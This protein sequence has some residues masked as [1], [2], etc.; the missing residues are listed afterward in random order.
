MDALIRSISSRISRSA[1]AEH[2]VADDLAEGRLAEPLDDAPGHVVH[3]RGRHRGAGQQHGRD[4]TGR[5]RCTAS[6]PCSRS[7]SSRAAKASATGPPRSPDRRPTG[8]RRRWTPRPPG[9]RP[10]TMTPRGPGRGRR[11]PACGGPGRVRPRRTRQAGRRPAATPVSPAPPRSTGRLPAEARRRRGPAARRSGARRRRRADRSSRRACRC[12]PP[13]RR[14]AGGRAT[15]RRAPASPSG[16]RSGGRIIL[17][18]ASSSTSIPNASGTASSRRPGERLPGRAIVRRPALRRPAG[19]DGAT[20]FSS[21]LTRPISSCGSN[22]LAS[23]PSQRT[24]R[25]RSSSTGSKAPVSSS[26]GMCFERRVALDEGRH[27]V[28]VLLRHADVGEHDVGA[29]RDD[30]VDRLLAVADGRHL[31]VLVGEGQLDDPLNRHAVVCEQEFVRHPVPTEQPKL[32]GHT[33]YIGR[34]SRPTTGVVAPVPSA[35]STHRCQRSRP[36]RSV[37]A[38]RLD[39]RLS[40]RVVCPP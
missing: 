20:S 3:E 2:D 27:L 32:G 16:G 12:R 13:A 24:A 23:T 10:A 38:G 40:Y 22:G 29:V 15:R 21:S 26:T 7:A 28:A 33:S 35:A 31:D 36:G 11:P 18:V 5:P 37:V 9:R 30:A 34:A 14:P 6:A 4:G 19:V 1:T 39:A 8:G 25:A 17:T